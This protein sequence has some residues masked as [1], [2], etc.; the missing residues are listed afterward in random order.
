MTATDRN[1][2]VEQWRAALPKRY[3]MPDLHRST[4]FGQRTY[5]PTKDPFVA[6]STPPPRKVLPAPRP[7]DANLDQ[8]DLKA[9][10]R[11]QQAASTYDEWR[12]LSRAID[13]ATG[14]DEWKDKD[15]SPVYD[16]A[17]VEEK[18]R[19]LQVARQSGNMPQLIYLVRTTF[20]RNLG[21]MGDHRLYRHCQCGTKRLIERYIN[22]CELALDYIV[23]HTREPKQVLNTLVETR[24][25]FG[26]TALV[27]SGGS[28]MGFLHAG[29]ARE[30]V[31][32]G[33][34]PKII[35]GTSAGSIFASLLCIYK[36]EEYENMWDIA[37][38]EIGIFEPI[39]Q[40]ES[41]LARLKR[42]LTVGTWIDSTYLRE[43]LQ[44]L[45][46]DVTF[47]EAYNRTGRILNVTVSVKGSHDMPRLLN[48][49]TAPNVL[50]W[51]A[52]LCS[53]SVPYVFAADSILAV[54]P[55]SRKL[56]PWTQ[57]SFMDGSVENDMPLSRLTE[58]FNVNHFV[59]CQV[60]P[61]IAPLVPRPLDSPERKLPK[62][63]WLA[64]KIS[65]ACRSA[66]SFVVDEIEYNLMLLKEAGLG[67]APVSVTLN[68]LLQDYYGDVTIVPPIYVGD[69]KTL[70]RNPSPDMMD[71]MI[72]RGAK[73][74]W[75]QLAIIRNH[76]A[77]EL[78]LDRAIVEV[79]SQC[80]QSIARLASP[81]PEEVTLADP[82]TDPRTI[83]TESRYRVRSSSFS[84]PWPVEREKIIPASA[85]HSSPRA[86]KLRDP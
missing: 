15:E 55:V 41:F 7:G 8:Q 62:R 24:K 82:R 35:S 38:Q 84:A 76:C 46:G 14:Q 67:G 30:L 13:A 58:M 37:K 28:V 50:I 39:G 59:A 27:L 19:A 69:L 77:V 66:T 51:S 5:V 81:V 52:V 47:Q 25:A 65:A 56:F 83:S 63:G 20:S 12:R 21:N 48:Y 18:L 86:L 3:S 2:E 42:F 23:R 68:L 75:P 29:V 34:L 54:D 44:D 26:S 1:F 11:A 60:N 33:L 17:K 80:I 22:E 57:A 71:E 45:L 85:M 73:T 6:P 78:A 4:I 74:T 61:H 36:E 40:A 32:H 49:L 9:L 16:Y 64:S 43:T 70:L 53:C 72:K 31:A 10:Q 79:R